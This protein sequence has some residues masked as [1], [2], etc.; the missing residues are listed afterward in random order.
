MKLYSPLRDPLWLAS[1]A[2]FALNLWWI[3]PN[4]AGWFWHGSLNDVL[5]LPVSMP[6]CVWVL[7]RLKWRDGGPPRAPEIALCLLFWSLIF[8]VLLPQTDVFGRFAAGDPLDVLA[9]AIGG[10]VG[11]IWWH[12]CV[13]RP[14]LR[15]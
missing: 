14:T 8:E 5:C 1:L 2:L 10:V 3:K 12:F 13:A 11:W 15:R 6:V 4:F 9:Y 7:A